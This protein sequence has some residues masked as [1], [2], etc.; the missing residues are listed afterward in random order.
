MSRDLSYTIWFSQRTGSTL[1]CEA[2]RSTGIAGRPGE[3]LHDV[4][5]ARS[6]AQLSSGEVAAWRSKIWVDGSTPN[7]VFGLKHSFY[8]PHFSSLIEALRRLPGAPGSESPRPQL[9]EHAFPN[10]HHIFM[11][12]RNKVRLAV[13]WWRAIQSQEWHRKQGTVP[14]PSDL[15]DAYNFDAIAH[16]L[17]ESVLREA[18]IQ[19]FF[20]EGEIVPL[21]VVYEDFITDYAGTVR[22]VIDFLGLESE[23]ITV[24]PPAFARIAGE[25][26]ERWVQRFRAEAQEGWTNRGW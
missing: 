3:W 13:S 26:A 18:G 1:L 2:L 19:A 4:D 21:T 8:E 9:W 20:A 22:R 24:A 17:R 15:A 12:R 23:D 25:V 5:A 14:Q 16:L 6:L 7:G 10:H 11:T